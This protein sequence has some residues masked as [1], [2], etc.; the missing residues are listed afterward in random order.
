M[1]LFRPLLDGDGKKEQLAEGSDRTDCSTGAQVKTAAEKA[2]E[3]DK[4]KR[5]E[6]R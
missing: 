1:I 5:A 2:K 3:K 6:K 4:L